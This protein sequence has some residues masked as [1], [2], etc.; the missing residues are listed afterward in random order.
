VHN[1]LLSLAAL[2]AM[3]IVAASTIC[4]AVGLLPALEVDLFGNKYLASINGYILSGVSIASFCSPFGEII[5]RE[6]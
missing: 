2:A 4:G 6:W 5:L 1:S 3:T